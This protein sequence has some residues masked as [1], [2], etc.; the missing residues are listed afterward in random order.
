VRIVGVVKNGH[1]RPS[2]R[3]VS[4]TCRARCA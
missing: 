1:I 4:M 3:R 2:A